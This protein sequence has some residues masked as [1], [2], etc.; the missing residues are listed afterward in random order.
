DPDLFLDNHAAP[1]ILDEIQ[2]APE[3]AAAVKRRVDRDKKPGS[4]VLTGS[5][6]WSVM[7]SIAESL[8]GR[9]V[10]LDL[11]GFSLSEIAMAGTTDS[12]LARYLRDPRDFTSS[13]VERLPATR[14][15]YEQLWRGFLPE[16]DTLDPEWIPEFHKAYLRT[17]VERDVRLVSEAQ[18]WQQFGRFVQVVSALTSQEVNRSQLGREIGVTPQT[19][20]RWLGSLQAGFQ[21]YE[22]APY[23][24]NAVK[25]ISGRPKGHL[26]DTGLA[27]GLQRISSPEALAGHPMAGALFESAVAGEIRKLASALPSSPNLYHWRTHGGAE[28]DLLLERDGVLHPIEVKLGTRPSK[29]DARGIAALRET[30]PRLRIAPGLVMAPV[31]R[32]EKLSESDFALPWDAR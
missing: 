8:A 31:E 18:D 10:F 24:G 30:Y 12:W 25:R 27:C 23:H 26:A 6:Q 28:V 17:Y 19:A 11:E 7:K 20:Q 1:L 21:W 4:Y 32:L 3:L 13:N 29:R 15:V 5:Q 16:A 14:P 22:V 9:A 2:Y